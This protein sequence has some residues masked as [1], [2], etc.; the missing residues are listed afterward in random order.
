MRNKDGVVVAFA[1]KE[2][3]GFNRHETF[4]RVVSIRYSLAS[5]NFIIKFVTKERGKKA[6]KMETSRNL[7]RR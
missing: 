7:M 3:D 1:C 5:D 2:V 4:S 6:V